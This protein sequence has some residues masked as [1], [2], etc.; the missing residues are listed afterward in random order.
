MKKYE[1]KSNAISDLIKNYR[2]KKGL[3][4]GEVCRRLQLHAVYL[5]ITE[6][7]RMETNRMIVKDFE[8]IALCK[9]LEIDYHDLLD[10]VL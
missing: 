6:L 2:I 7:N 3:S 5:D 8:L 9:V 1:N 10:T 4:K